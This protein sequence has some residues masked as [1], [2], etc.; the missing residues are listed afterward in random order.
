M[1]HPGFF[2]RAAPMPLH[3]LAVAVEAEIADSRW[4]DRLIGDVRALADAGPAHLSFFHNRKFLGQLAATQA[5]A[6]LVEAAF[7]RRVPTTAAVLVSLSPYRS[8]ALAMRLFY[9]DA[10]HP[11]AAVGTGR[12][13]IDPSAQIENGVRVE[14]GAVIGAEAAIGRGTTIAAGAVIGYRCA[15][16]RDCYIGPQATLTHALIGDR[17]IVHAGARIGQDGFG[18]A[19]GPKG[20]VK[21]PQIGRVVIQD[22]VEIG[23]NTTIDRGALRDTIVG[24]GTKID[25]LVQIAHNVVIG[26]HCIIVGQAGLAGS[27]ELGDFVIVGGQ[28]GVVGHVEIGTGAHIAGGSHPTH[29]VPPG[30]RVGGTPARP[31]KQWARE[32]AALKRLAAKSTDRNRSDD[33]TPDTVSG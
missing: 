22:D 27:S 17:V 31:L 15:V 28:A 16:G 14:P 30:A 29:D 21:V 4:G 32:L 9:P 7:A 2:E 5:G 18:Y 33:E 26:R 23:A 6:C 12:D 11:K 25:N 8:F 1:D 10:R 13:V 19:L 20:H 24:E 3:R